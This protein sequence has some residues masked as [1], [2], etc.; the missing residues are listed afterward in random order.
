MDSERKGRR[1]RRQRVTE[2]LKSLLIAVLAV[3]AIY[4]AIRAQFYSELGVSKPVGWLGALLD[5]MPERTVP[6]ESAVVSDGL[7]LMAAQA[8]RMAVNNGENRFAVQYDTTQTDRAF[9]GASSLLS[10]GL[11]SAR[12]PRQIAERQW[13][14]ALG[15]PGIYFDFLG[16]IPLDALYA[17][18][19]EGGHNESLDGVAR[20][21]L[22]AYDG[23]SS[24]L[25]Y[26]NNED[27]GMYYACETSVVYE[28]HLEDVVT[29]FSGNSASFAFE[30]TDETYRGVAPYVLIL[31]Q[32]PAPSIYRSTN[33]LSGDETKVDQVVR[34]LSFRTQSSAEYPMPNGT[35]IREGKETLQIND[36]GSIHYN[37]SELEASRYAVGEIEGA[38]GQIEMARKLAA[39]TIGLWCGS[40]R[41]YLMEYTARED[42]STVVRFGYS[43][44]GAAVQLYSGGY[45]AQFTF[46]EG[47]LTDYLLHFRAYEDSGE[48]RAV[49]PERQAAAALGALKPAEQ[50]LLL[51]YEDSGGDST[52]A[53]WI[54]G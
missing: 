20:R 11:A 14:D 29:T 4:L 49:L 21:I 24:V 2:T 19:G 54:A 52:S 33:P 31:P 50:E 7:P 38:V 39:E 6:P 26:Y 40:A 36:G 3:S 9:D 53:G 34:A 23:S 43:L 41:L 1:S 45:S 22:L 30:L 25:L 51:C 13:R 8:V 35:M 12:A 48:D 28:G 37:A 47:R 18:L 44:D 32:P 15:R 5:L 16:G 17:W 27:T 10:E 42:G 46:R